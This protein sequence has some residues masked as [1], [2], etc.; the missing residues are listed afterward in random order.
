MKTLRIA[1][2]KTNNFGDQ[3]LCCVNEDTQ[4]FEVITR[5][6]GDHLQLPCPLTYQIF[7]V[8]ENFETKVIKKK[9]P[10]WSNQK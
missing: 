3:I 1:H 10:K 9:L 8:S 7:L 2:K 5:Q 4:E 6:E